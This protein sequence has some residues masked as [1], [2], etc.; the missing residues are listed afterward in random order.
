M[1]FFTFKFFD[2][3]L[4]RASAF[5]DSQNETASGNHTLL[6]RERADRSADVVQSRIPRLG[7]PPT[8]GAYK[9]KSVKWRKP[10]KGRQANVLVA[11]LGV[12]PLRIA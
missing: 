7:G 3:N 12:G 4:R 8:A 10:R 2:L 5:V 6:P 1:K 9:D 11:S